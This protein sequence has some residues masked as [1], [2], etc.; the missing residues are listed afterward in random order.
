MPFTYKVVSNPAD[1]RS[2]LTR[3]ILDRNDIVYTASSC[4]GSEIRVTTP[5]A[6]VDLDGLIDYLEARSRPSDRLY[7]DDCLAEQKEIVRFAIELI[8]M[9]RDEIERAI[10]RFSTDPLFEIVWT[11]DGGLYLPEMALSAAFSPIALCDES[12]ANSDLGQFALII[13]RRS[14]TRG[15]RADEYSP[16]RNANIRDR[17]MIWLQPMA[18]EANRF[19]RVTKWL[20]RRMPVVKIGK[21]CLVTRHN[22]ILD[23][24]RRDEEFTISQINGPRMD[25]VSGPFILGMDRSKRFNAELAAIQAVVQPGDQERVRNIVRTEAKKLLAAAEPLGQIDVV[26]SYAR[27]VAARVTAQYLGVPGKSEQLLCLCMRSMFWEVFENPTNYTCVT[28][29]A[30][31]SGQHVEVHLER[32]IAHLKRS[33]DD[34][35]LSR[36]VHAGT[37]DDE[38]VRRNITGIAVGAVDTT[39]K[40]VAQILG[41]LFSQPEAYELARKAAVAG[42]EAQLLQCCYEALRFNPQTPLL[43]R[44]SKKASKVLSGG[45]IKAYRTVCLATL[46][47]MFDPDGFP[48]PD[49]FD[50]TRP[51]D[52]YLHFGHGMHLCYGRYVNAIQIPELVGEILKYRPQQ[53]S[54]IEYEGP[55][56]DRFLVSIQ[57]SPSG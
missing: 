27:L 26:G 2:D 17:I 53:L 24:F 21:I 49:R 9:S 41:V 19:R 7:R 29:A 13:Y 45:T 48:D 12:A 39:N 22:D 23:V 32:R 56:P 55:Y 40:A 50:T 44:H 28:R 1:P 51:I 35:I 33:P 47:A 52:S 34:S 37:L 30:I 16:T 11:N 38:G 36:L 57:K 31:K 42:D 5:D 15:Y 46:S 54:P 8:G 25:K 14:R 6:E 4:D 43:L 3:W 10:E 20:R 18:L